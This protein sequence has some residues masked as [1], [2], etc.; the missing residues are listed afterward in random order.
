MLQIPSDISSR[1][2]QRPSGGRVHR[3]LPEELRSI[4]HLPTHP[5][6]RLGGGG[7]TEAQLQTGKA[8]TE[9][10]KGAQTGCENTMLKISPKA[11]SCAFISSE[12]IHSKTIARPFKIWNL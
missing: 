4:R 2:T 5:S 9:V 7:G 3:T 12:E 6:F 11:F 10:L 1:L 8:K